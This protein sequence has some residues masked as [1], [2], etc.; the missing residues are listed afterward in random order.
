LLGD[1]L[2]GPRVIKVA[3]VTNFQKAGTFPL[4]ALLLSHFGN[5]AWVY[6]AMQG[7]IG[8]VWLLK[9]SAFPDA[10]F[11]K[12]VTFGG[13]VNTFVLLL[14]W[15]WVMGWTLISR[16]VTPAYPLPAEAWFCI[17]ISLCM[18]GCA[19]MIAADAQKYFTLR[20]QPGLITDGMFRYV[21]H[22]NYLG[23]IMI[24]GSFALMVWHW[25]ASVILAW[26]WLGL[27]GTSLVL[28]E[29]SLSRHP[30]WAAYRRHSW[31]LFPGVL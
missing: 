28:K 13:A 19:I 3:W 22:P 5:T 1:F 2:G 18:L 4:Y 29:A 10:S 15:Y 8:L 11:E 26:I 25:L 12:R 16:N 17:C 23:E 24:Y 20:L 14:G 21:R 7:T 6:V 31:W 27:F 30:G 9:S